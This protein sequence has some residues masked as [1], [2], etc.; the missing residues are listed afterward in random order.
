[1]TIDHQKFLENLWSEAL[2]F[3]KQLTS[4][5]DRGC[6]L[7]ATAYLDKVLSDLLYCSVVYEPKKID[8]EL[9][10]FNSPLGTFSSRIKMAYYLGQ[11]SKVTRR[12]LDLLRKI[13]N[14]FAH[15]PTVTSFND[16]DVANQCRELKFSF[17]KKDDD[18]R[19]HFLGAVFGLLAQLQNAIF[20]AVAPDQKPDDEPT[21]A[22]KVAHMKKLGIDD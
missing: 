12:D 11:I 18:P 13:R 1:M 7:F 5:S 9:F 20:S 17:R 10:E 16:E 4:E 2:A 21:E 3:R 22:E 14:K 19:S 6:A 8:K 15:H